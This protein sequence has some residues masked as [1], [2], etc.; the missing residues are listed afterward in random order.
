MRT[1]YL[2]M[3]G[4]IG[5]REAYLDKAA[6][7]IEQNCGSI[8]RSSS[9]YETAAWGNTDQAAFYNQAVS[10]STALTPED[11]L[12]QLLTIELQMGR[13]RNIYMGPRTIDLDILLMDDLVIHT[14]QLQVPHPRLA[15]RRFALTPLAEIAPELVHPLLHKTIA[16]LLAECTDDSDVQKKIAP[17][18]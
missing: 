11:L 5:D 2:L 1:A 3:G 4:N 18:F 12:Q 10:I 9:I 13:T 6:K 15:D 17:G 7:K 8:I 14:A 16:V